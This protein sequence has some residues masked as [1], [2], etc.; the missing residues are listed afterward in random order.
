MTVTGLSTVN[1]STTTPLQQ[2]ILFALMLLGD[3]VRLIVD[4][5]VLHSA[6]KISFFR[7]RYLL[8]WCSCGS[9]ELTRTA[10]DGY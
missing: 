4:S 8:L 5:H 10:S 3:V 7:L 9:G 2:F 6:M 1:L